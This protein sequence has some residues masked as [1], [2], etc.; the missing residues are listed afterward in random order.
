LGPS[1]SLPFLNYYSIASS[2][3]RFAVLVSITEQYTVY[4]LNPK[5]LNP[6]QQLA[7]QGT[8][9]ENPAQFGQNLG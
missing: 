7:S 1:G 3:L 2:I 6:L 8:N 4:P 5:T 9:T